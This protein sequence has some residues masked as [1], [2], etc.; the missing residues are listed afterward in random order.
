MSRVFAGLGG[1]VAAG[2]LL[3]ACSNST[4]PG[5][6]ALDAVSPTPGATSIPVT[7]TVSV[8]FSQPMTAGMEQYMDLHQGGVNGPIVAMGCAWH[9][10]KTTLTCTPNNLLSA[11]TTYSIHMGG[12]LTDAQGG[13][14][15]M[16]NWTSMG[17]QWVE[18][19]MMGSTHGGMS[20]GMMGSG[21]KDGM[22][23]YGMMF[24][25]TTN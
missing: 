19:G 4:A 22:G 25:F 21:W 17:G 14:I 5:S 1:A 2:L 24:E 10:D 18:S 20:V 9:D 7:T 3:A 8:T 11:G 23:H 6:V 15:R 16:G 12:G 13:M